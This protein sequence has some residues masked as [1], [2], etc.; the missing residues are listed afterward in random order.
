METLRPGPIAG[1]VVLLKRLVPIE[2]K[3]V[4]SFV[5]VGFVIWG[6]RAIPTKF[7]RVKRCIPVNF[8]TIDVP[9]LVPQIQKPAP[10]RF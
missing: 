4:E 2:F 7:E 6:G 9:I 3:E 10:K 5:P 1:E 8:T